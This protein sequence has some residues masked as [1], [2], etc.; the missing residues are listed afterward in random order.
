MPDKADGRGTASLRC[1]QVGPSEPQRVLTKYVQGHKGPETAKR[2][3]EVSDPVSGS[4]WHI[5]RSRKI[6]ADLLLCLCVGRHRMR[7]QIPDYPQK[8]LA[9]MKEG[10]EGSAATG[11]Q[12]RPL[13]VAP[14]LPFLH[15]RR[16]GE[17]PHSPLRHAPCHSGTQL[18]GEQ[19]CSAAIYAACQPLTFTSWEALMGCTSPAAV[20]LYACTSRICLLPKV[21]TSLPAHLLDSQSNCSRC[22]GLAS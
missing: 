8:V 13:A 5:I 1:V 9:A 16:T 12:C 15:C 7:G 20:A 4:H 14:A 6:C 22:H 21:C 2:V 17:H 11:A 3:S 18:L 10:Q 19:L